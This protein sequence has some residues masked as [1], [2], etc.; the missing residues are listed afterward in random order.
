MKN[1]SN[2][3]TLVGAD[4]KPERTLSSSTYWEFEQRTDSTNRLF[5]RA[6]L[7]DGIDV[8]SDRELLFRKKRFIMTEV[9][10]IKDSKEIEII[11]DE[12][13]A[14]L[15]DRGQD[16]DFIINGLKLSDAMQEALRGSGWTVG[17]VFEDD[18]NYYAEME[19]TNVTGKLKF[20]ERQSSGRL[21]FD[22]VARVVHI[23]PDEYATP[24]VTFRYG[25]GMDGIEK[26]EEPPQATVMYAYGRNGMTIENVN[27]GQ[28]YI[29]D[30][31]YYTEQGVDIAYAR[32]RYRKTQ[33]I[34][35]ERF[36]YNTNLYREARR[37]LNILSRPS[38]NYTFSIIGDDAEDRYL[39]EPIYIVDE[40]IDV[41]I[42]THISKILVCSDPSKNEIEAD[43]MPESLNANEIETGDATE[44]G[45]GEMQLFQNKNLQNITVTDEPQPI[46]ELSIST[47]VETY[48]KIG[49]TIEFEVIT[50]GLIEG[51]FMLNEE[52]LTRRIRQTVSPGFHTIGIPFVEQNIEEGENILEL[53]IQT[54]GELMIDEEQ[55]EMYVMTTGAFG[56]YITSPD[57]E[58][59]DEIPKFMGN[60]D[61]Y[62]S[63]VTIVL[64]DSIPE[65]PEGDV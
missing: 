55:A 41:K 33:T 36:I 40:E 62:D 64:E 21:V 27:N 14:E 29:E 9:T 15:A 30:Y 54:T 16:H 7:K 23:V 43:H 5:V 12:G 49:V 25:K 37:R 59:A 32:E 57:R 19:N 52:S 10:R 13:Q 1:V 2:T 65:E 53:F 28:E 63:R 3:I 22:S 34:K 39:H 6:P 11:A 45:S 26:T 61:F 56:N 24:E 8:Y 20:L 60:A 42:N 50:G 38:I 35:D 51:Y 58:V 47:Y 46:L 31:S 4:N 18:R 48:F 17:Y 44:G